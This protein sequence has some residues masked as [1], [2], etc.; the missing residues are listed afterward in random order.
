MEVVNFKTGP[1]EQAGGRGT[2]CWIPGQ[3][4]RCGSHNG[5]LINV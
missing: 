3:E 4:Y 2:I 1:E 5:Q